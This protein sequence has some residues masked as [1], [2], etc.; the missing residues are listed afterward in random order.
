MLKIFMSSIWCACFE[1]LG[2]SE[3]IGI[4][5]VSWNLH[6]KYLGDNFISGEKLKPDTEKTAGFL[7]LTPVSYLMRQV[8]M[9]SNVASNSTRS[10]YVLHIL[11]Y[12][13]IAFNF[14]S[15]QCDALSVCFNSVYRRIFGFNKW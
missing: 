6:M 5:I 3:F 2:T 11:L 15:A 4:E 9:K 1:S 13:C 14:T 7:Q 12:T 10:L 8:V